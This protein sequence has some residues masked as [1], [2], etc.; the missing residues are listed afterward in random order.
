MA[1]A[2]EPQRYADED[3]ELAAEEEEG[4]ISVMRRGLNEVL[5]C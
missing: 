4:L 1:Q 2:G 5:T 3:L